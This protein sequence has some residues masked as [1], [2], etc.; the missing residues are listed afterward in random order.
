MK[1]TIRTCAQC[2]SGG[3]PSKLRFPAFNVDGYFRKTTDLLST[4]D[5]PSGINF[6]DQMMQNIGNLENYG[7]EFAINVKPI[8]TKDFTWDLSYNVGWNHN[9]ITEL[10]A[11]GDDY[12]WVG[13]TISRGNGT[14][15][16]RNAVGYPANSFFVYQQVYDKMG[17]PIEGMYVDR[18]ADG[19]IND[20]DRYYFKKPAADVVMG[21]TTKFLWKNWDLSAAF[22]ASLGNYVYYDF[23]SN[24]ASLDGLYTN[25]CFHNTTP[26]A[27]ALGFSGVTTVG[28]GYWISD[29][30]VRNA[31][32]VKC[33]N[34]TLGYTFP[35]LFKSHLSGRIFA[36][37]Q[38]PF[39]I[40]KYKGIDPEV[41]S[42]I[43][44][45][46]YPRPMSFQLG[47]NLNF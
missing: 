29:Y 31:S 3:R 4:V 36:T 24:N 25:S 9:E 44:R 23:L 5:I 18:N 13:N 19:M 11:G 43:D 10:N 8:V 30:F 7:L 14:R 39:M 26:E 47:V 41:A 28:D 1:R 22:H 40:T 38:N 27:V 42:G 21:L 45:N 35:A 2:S 34:I 16:Q 15:I 46:P 17:K 6:G 32:Y 33:S 37:A 20:D 12:V